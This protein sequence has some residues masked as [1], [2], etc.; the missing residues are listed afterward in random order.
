MKVAII[1]YWLVGMR[2]GEKVI[3]ALCE[4]YPQADIYTHVY[5]PEMV[6]ETIRR[7]RVIPTFINAL[8]RGSTALSRIQRRLHGASTATTARIRWSFIP[9]STPTRFRSPQP[10]NWAIII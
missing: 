4:M 1:H 8:P 2:G 10:P 3:E 7:H 5:V 6:S 9:P